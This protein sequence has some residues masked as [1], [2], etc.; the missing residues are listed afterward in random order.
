[1]SNSDIAQ[2]NATRFSN[3]I[4]LRSTA[5]N[6][7]VTYNAFQKVFRHR[8]EDGRSNIRLG[9]F[10]NVRVTQPLMTG[11]RVAYERLLGKN[12]E[13]FYNT[14]FYSNNSLAVLND[15]A[16]ANNSLNT[17]FF[18]FPFLLSALSDSAHFVWFDW[19]TK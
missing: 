3:P 7:I 4:R 2:S 14:T 9:Q 12:K 5:R 19:Y 11:N 17:Y 10:A 6:S 13:S 16:S 1:M 18:D 8:L 15:L